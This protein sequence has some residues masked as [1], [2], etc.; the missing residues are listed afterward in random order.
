MASKRAVV[1]SDAAIAKAKGLYPPGGSA[2]G[3]PA[4][5]LFEDTILLAAKTAFALGFD[6]LPLAVEDV[7]AIRF[8]VTHGLPFFPATV[9]YGILLDTEVVEIVDFEPDEDYF[10]MLEADPPD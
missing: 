5:A 3:R 2:D 1:V 4:F 10:A 8:V 9:F 6:G 7:A